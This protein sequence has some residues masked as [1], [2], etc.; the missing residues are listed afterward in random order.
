M[1]SLS[2]HNIFLNRKSLSNL[3]IWEPRSFKVSPCHKCKKE[4]KSNKKI[5]LQSI[6]NL[7]WCTAFQEKIK[8]VEQLAP[9]PTNVTVPKLE[10]VD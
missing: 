9:P 10:E 2:R 7:A 5:C 6:V 8:G 3:A 4:L 1:D